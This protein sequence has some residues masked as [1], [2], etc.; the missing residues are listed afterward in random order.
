MYLVLGEGLLLRTGLQSLADFF[1][2]LH[3]GAI[4][5]FL[6]QLWQVISA[7]QQLLGLCLVL[8]EL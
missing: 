5:P 7:K 1:P 4:C 2:D 8:T 6:P 3:T